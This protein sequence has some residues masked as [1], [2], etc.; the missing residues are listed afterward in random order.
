MVLYAIKYQYTII[1]TIQQLDKTILMEEKYDIKQWRGESPYPKFSEVDCSFIEQCALHLRIEPLRCADNICH[2]DWS[3]PPRILPNGFYN[4][5]ISGRCRLKIAAREFIIKPGDV[6]LIPP[7]MEHSMFLLDGKGA[8]MIHIHFTANV[9]GAADLISL[10]DAAGRVDDKT[11]DPGGKIFDELTRLEMLKPPAWKSMQRNS[12]ELL[13]LRQIYSAVSKKSIS[14]GRFKNIL[15][16]QPVLQKIDDGLG[17]VELSVNALAHVISVSPVYL[18]KLF[19]SALGTSP[20]AFLH[21]RRID[22]ACRLLQTTDMAIKT[23]ANRCGFNDLQFFYRVFKKLML[24]TPNQYR[25]KIF[26]KGFGAV[27]DE[28]LL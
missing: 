1:K 26:Y 24:L 10:L 17:D 7:R 22:M 11:I 8:Q 15:R 9:Y 3:M 28:E 4:R 14:S 5:M 16:L 2:A 13:L 20:I 25:R 12:I 21:G 23:V 6:T 27:P 18:R 19:Q